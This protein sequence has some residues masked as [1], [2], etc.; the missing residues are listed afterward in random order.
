M[1]G[2]VVVVTGSRSGIGRACAESFARAGDTVIATVRDPTTATP[3]R[4]ALADAGD[5]AEVRAL[6]VTDDAQVT[7]AIGA[8]LDAHGRV[9]VLVAN[10]AISV[11]ATLEDLPIDELRRVLDVNVLGAARVMKAVLPAMRR[12][13]GGRIIAVSSMGGVLGQPF[14]DAY[15]ASKFALEGLCAS[16][17]PVAAVNGVRVTLVEPGP[18]QG[19]FLDKTP[20]IIAPPH[21]TAY[22][23]FVA[24]RRAAYAVAPEPA[25][26]AG[27]IV[28]IADD[29]DPPLRCQTADDVTRTVAHVTK[30]VDG[31]RTLGLTSG[32][33]R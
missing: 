23:R 12:A 25:D 20:S 32:W 5:R 26:I 6:D 3:L 15:C 31:S 18:V 24:V 10:A 22:A 21:E 11:E 29:P 14:N 17:A 30:D 2:R 9:D 16:F 8:V 7:A 4:A 33:L 28:A 19:E 1:A 13:G 27:V